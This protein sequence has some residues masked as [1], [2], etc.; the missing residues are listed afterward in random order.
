[1]KELDGIK[2]F[3]VQDIHEAFGMSIKYIRK[4][5]SSGEIKGVKINKHW[6][7]TKESIREYLERKGKI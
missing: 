6:Y 5:F 1:M 2:V 3:S 7:G 4:L